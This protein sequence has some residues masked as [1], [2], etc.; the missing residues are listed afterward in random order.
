MWMQAFRVVVVF[1][2]VMAALQIIG[3]LLI[4]ASA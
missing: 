3:S 1:V 4:M 2:V